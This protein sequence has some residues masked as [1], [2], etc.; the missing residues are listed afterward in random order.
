M[1]KKVLIIDDELM[2]LDA[3]K[4]ILE[5]LGYLVDAFSEPSAGEQAGI[6]GEYDL[7]L[8]DLRMPGRNGA[9]VVESVLKKR[10]R[11]R[12]LVITAFPSD[13][14]ADQALSHG[15]I[16]LVRKPFEI[17]KIVEY[18]GPAA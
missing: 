8:S 1:P 2:V 6:D 5:G 12:I 10:P 11:A 13:P 17:S 15:A 3:L 7:I 4:V 18:L 14:L 16:G 9:D